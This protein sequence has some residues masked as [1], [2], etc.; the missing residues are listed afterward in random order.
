MAKEVAVGKRA[1]ISEAQQ[2]MLLA[3]FG[4][5]I[6]FG[7]ALCLTINFIKQI[8][9]NT[10]VIMAEEQSIASYSDIIA[11]TG[12][13]KSPR[14]TIYTKEELEAC[15][16]DAIDAE[17]VPNTLRSNILGE[18][19]ANPAL[20]SV[21]KEANSNCINISTGKNYTYNE[22]NKIYN[23]AKN[24]DELI[25]AS[26]LLKSCSAL[27]II[28]DAL[29]AFM[30]GEALLASFNKIAIISGWQPDS[31]SPGDS[32]YSGDEDEEETTDEENAVYGM[33]V[34]FT[35][36]ADTSTAA[37]FLKNLE[38]SIREFDVK[39]AHINWEETGTLKMEAQANAYFIDRSTIPE[40]EEKLTADGGQNEN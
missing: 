2:Y 22:L 40:I 8:S 1:K 34:A 24:S 19:A 38:R 3:V 20:G 7:V 17:D 14:G 23:E 32:A 30:N 5:S 37:N 25:A 15:D 35:L 12:V 31:I 18:I 10:T 6:V 28:P 21:P 33:T 13:C 11:T 29:P 4:A 16:P 26:Q 9:F 39:E 27:R 36:E